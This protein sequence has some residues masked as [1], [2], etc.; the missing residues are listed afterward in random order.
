MRISILGDI[1]PG[2]V[3]CYQKDYIAP[4]LLQKLQ[5]SAFRIATLECA[6]GGFDGQHYDPVKMEGR[7]NIIYA[8]APKA[9]Q[10]LK[11][12]NIN[13]VSLAN[14]HVFDL[15][16]EGLVFTMKQLEEA[17]ILYG[18]AGRNLAEASRPV[19]F[20]ADGMRICILMYCDTRAYTVAHV[21]VAGK[22][23]PGINPLRIEQVV[24]DIKANRTTHDFVFVLPHWGCEYHSFP[25][26][27][28]VRFAKRMITA[29]AD[30]VF[31]THTHQ[32]QPSAT[33]KTRPIFYSLGNALFPDFYIDAPRP[34]C[35]P[36]PEAD[37]A[38]IP[39]TT[40]YPFPVPRLLKRVWLPGS[41]IGT[42][43]E[44]DIENHVLRACTERHI[45]LSTK[46]IIESASLSIS[47]K[48]K[49]K[50]I[51]CMTRLPFYQGG[52]WVRR[53]LRL[54]SSIRSTRSSH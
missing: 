23:C 27:E 52:K 30:G 8:P 10:I 14:N 21:P 35:Y 1:M 3:L 26:A 28:D 2:G 25:L 7:K 47:H 46:N 51:G 13:I 18:G 16:T 44:I 9:I 45:R 37:L 29:G 22:D 12:L 20:E 40:D 32:I 17:G 19:S 5:Q 43:A 49:L 31:G 36:N 41:R 38:A 6:L 50:A 24:A 33:Y 42:I 54:I 39:E 53:I 48:Q 11:E 34:I 15:D 4:E